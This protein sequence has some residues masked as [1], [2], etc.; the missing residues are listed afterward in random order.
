ME[1]PARH[2]VEIIYE[3]DDYGDFDGYKRVYL[4]LRMEKDRHSIDV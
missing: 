1:H 3:Y 4:S 2:M